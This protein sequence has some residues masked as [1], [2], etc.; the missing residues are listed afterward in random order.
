MYR[1]VSEAITRPQ[2]ESGSSYTVVLKEDGTV[3]T[4]GANEV[5]QLGNG[6]IT[7]CSEREGQVK[8]DA[9]TVLSNVVKISTGF[10][11][12]LAITRDGYV[13]AWGL[14]GNGQLGNNS[15]ANQPYAVKVL[16]E[17]GK[18]YLRDIIDVSAGKAFSTFLDKNGNV[19][20]VGNGKN[21][22]LGNS[23]EADIY[24]VKKINVS[25]VISIS[26]GLHHTIA[27]KQDGVLCGWGRNESNYSL[28]MGTLTDQ[29]VPID[30]AVKNVDEIS[31]AGYTGLVKTEDGKIYGAGWNE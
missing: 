21:Y 10:N 18:S 12:T 1:N 4:S 13:Y 14:N 8:I 26:S 7:T 29:S 5:G 6:K 16:A 15:T 23:S 28:G 9:N 17:D 11:H 24:V 19:Y 2:I 30:L 25:N 22:R 20:T 27:I 31:A 3:W